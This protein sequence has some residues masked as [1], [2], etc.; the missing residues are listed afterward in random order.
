MIVKS[1]SRM[2]IQ[3]Q[4]VTKIKITILSA[5]DHGSHGLFPIPPILAIAAASRP[6]VEQVRSPKS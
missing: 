5:S 3:A 4:A 6:P 2:K 1:P